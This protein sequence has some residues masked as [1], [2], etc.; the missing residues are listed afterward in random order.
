MGNQ[1]EVC[2]VYPMKN[3]AVLNKELTKN[4][5]NQQIEKVSCKAS[6]EFR[7]DES[8]KAFN[9]F[10]NDKRGWITDVTDVNPH[11]IYC[12]GVIKETG[13]RNAV[14]AAN[15]VKLI[16]P[17]ST[18]NNLSNV[19]VLGSL[20]GTAWTELVNIEVRLW[21]EEGIFFI[22]SPMVCNFFKVELT[23]KNEE[24]ECTLFVEDI[25]FYGVVDNVISK[26]EMDIK[27][28][29]EALEGKVDAEEGKVLS[30]NDFTNEHL[31]SLNQAFYEVGLVNTKPLVEWLDAHD[32]SN[33]GKY[34]NSRTEEP[35]N[36]SLENFTFDENNGFI[37]GWLTNKNTDNGNNTIE[38]KD[39]ALTNNNVWSV[40][41]AM[42]NQGKG[43]LVLF[44]ND[45]YETNP[46]SPY[47]SFSYGTSIFGMAYEISIRDA[48]GYLSTYVAQANTQ[49]ALKVFTAVRNGNQLFFHIDGEYFGEIRDA[50]DIIEIDPNLKFTHCYI[51]GNPTKATEYEICT[52]KLY[53]AAVTSVTINPDN[54]VVMNDLQAKNDLQMEI[55]TRLKH[56]EGVHTILDNVQHQLTNMQAGNIY[57]KKP[58]GTF[59]NLQ[60]GLT[61]IFNKISSLEAEVAA[62]K[63]NPTV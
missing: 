30:S 16:I 43:D 24:V 51:G 36:V 58:D 15:K 26:I 12:T 63:N 61:E 8:A 31:R 54:S 45:D 32:G 44:C 37:D 33:E 53:D 17:K 23:R 2:L 52:I 20:N 9:A 34:W 3:N 47:V 60:V 10:N 41:V 48:T 39:I 22:E 18:R 13:V 55:S 40:T 56:D 38:V 57:C 21:P 49:Y 14:T 46:N 7:F 6:S 62:L 11:I 29:E 50:N 1:R 25:R 35:T 27:S 19:K 4:E 59:V 42:R 5:F 28:V